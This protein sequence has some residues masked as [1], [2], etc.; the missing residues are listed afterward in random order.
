MTNAESKRSKI[1]RGPASNTE[2]EPQF[3]QYGITS[4]LV[5]QSGESSQ[6]T[7]ARA[8]RYRSN[9]PSWDTG[10]RLKQNYEAVFL[11]LRD[12]PDAHFDTDRR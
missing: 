6:R 9:P 4:Y 2:G 7:F 1:F 5:Q 10:Q 12:I 11:M 8:V 3:E